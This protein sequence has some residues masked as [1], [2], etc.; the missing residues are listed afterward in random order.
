MSNSSQSREEYKCDKC[1]KVYKTK[2]RFE[3]HLVNSHNSNVAVNTPKMVPKQK[4]KPNLNV[5]P[6]SHKQ[7]KQSIASPRSDAVSVLSISVRSKTESLDKEHKKLKEK[8]REIEKYYSEKLKEL[9]SE[10]ASIEKLKNAILTLRDRLSVEQKQKEN[11]ENT[12]KTL[13]NDNDIL[14]N[15][16]TNYQKQRDDIIASL[17][18]IKNTNDALNM[19]LEEKTRTIEQNKSIITQLLSEKDNI[20]ETL[21]KKFLEQLNIKENIITN[22]QK[23]Q[24]ALTEKYQNILNSLKSNIETENKNQTDLYECEIH[25][26][27]K[28]YTDELK[29]VSEAH[30]NTLNQLLVQFQTDKRVITDEFQFRISNLEEHIK[31]LSEKLVKQEKEFIQ[32][33]EQ[34]ERLTKEQCLSYVKNVEMQHEILITSLKKDARHREEILSIN[35]GKLTDE[36]R[37][38]ETKNKQYEEYILK[39]KNSTTSIT[40]Q[41]NKNINKHIEINKD[42]IKEKDEEIR[43]LTASIENIKTDFI[44]KLNNYEERLKESQEKLKKEKEEQKTLHETIENREKQYAELQMALFNVNLN[45]KKEFSEKDSI[46]SSLNKKITDLTE[47]EI[48]LK[49]RTKDFHKT[50]RDYEISLNNSLFEIKKLKDDY[51]I[52]I[53]SKDEEKAKMESTLNSRIFLLENSLDNAKN[54]ILKERMQT[55]EEINNIK[56][57]YEEKLKINDIQTIQI[58]QDTIIDD[59]KVS[60]ELSKY[61]TDIEELN[62]RISVIQ[63]THLAELNNKEIEIIGLKA[64]ITQLQ[65]KMNDAVIA[66]NEDKQKISEKADNAFRI[67]KNNYDSE[68][69]RSHT[70]IR[71]LNQEIERIKTDFKNNLNT[72]MQQ[73][74]N[75]ICE[76]QKDNTILTQLLEKERFDYQNKYNEER[77][78]FRLH[79]EKNEQKLIHLNNIIIG[80][81][82]EI[83]KLKQAPALFMRE[84][85]LK[86]EE[87]FIREKKLAEETQK[88]IKMLPIPN[89]NAIKQSRDQ[90]FEKIKHQNVQINEMDKTIKNLESSL[91]DIISQKDAEIDFY[92]KAQDNI[93]KEYSN[94]LKMTQDRFNDELGKK[95]NRIKELESRVL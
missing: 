46:I 15:I 29:T 4:D 50:T 80:K 73:H 89:D 48:I 36:N 30:Q 81:D 22:L 68:I 21:N 13:Q 53:K 78:S 26:L 44:D 23:E 90:A 76:L 6:N 25:H 58:R 74:S 19:N 55:V 85:K 54:V 7:S 35:I 70:E 95:E 8:E 18:S 84:I 38:L 3:S 79:N 47:A 49:E 75:R 45:V 77:N 93:K 82:Q 20:I 65:T 14:Q 12:N 5:V 64:H 31:S 34:Q 42:A 72:Q 69:S 63:G 39:I 59:K 41:F 88:R 9:E 87:L 33:K 60:L 40:E 56:K 57:Q 27:Q 43:I 66:Y 24:R 37:I 62:K 71:R 61:K 1:F 28:K 2:T 83:E 16:I 67:A 52:M 17:R 11:L 32:N 94:L 10:N 51:A 86:E 92:K 91:R